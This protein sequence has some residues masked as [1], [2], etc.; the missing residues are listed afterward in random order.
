MPR[1]PVPRPP[2]LA[3]GAVTSPA[4][5]F[6]PRPVP[7]LA[8]MD[9]ADVVGDE[10]L[11][12]RRLTGTAAGSDWEHVDLR[13]CTLDGAVL[14]GAR[15]TACTW[16]DVVCSLTD[17]H[18]LAADRLR[19]TRLLLTGCRLSGATF[20]AA[21]LVDVE[22]AQVRA[23]DLALRMSRVRRARF[24]ECSLT[25]LDLTESELT[26]VVFDSCDLTGSTFQGARLAAVVFRGCRLTEVSGVTGLRG[27]RI[28][29]RSLDE[30]APSLARGLGIDIDAPAGT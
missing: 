17:L 23:P 18:G 25:G 14:A 28:D 7:E 30:L 24:T 29:S 13:S 10:L 20:T 9:A 21:E 2:A 1:S 22:L 19:A 8:G 26:D 11:T 15:L 12:E 27:A 5:P 6:A 4:P 16:Q 3:R